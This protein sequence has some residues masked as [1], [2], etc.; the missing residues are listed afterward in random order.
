M[1]VRAALVGFFALGLGLLLPRPALAQAPN[2]QISYA[3][4]MKAKP[5]SWAEY[6]MSREGEEQ[7]VRARYTLVRKDPKGVALEIDSK[8]KESHIFID[9]V[10]R[11]GV[12]LTVEV[13]DGEHRV[14]AI[15]ALSYRSMVHKADWARRHGFFVSPPPRVDGNVILSGHGSLGR[16]YLKVDGADGNRLGSKV[17]LAPGKRTIEVRAAR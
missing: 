2:N 12:P 16:A 13:P 4:I 17:A 3:A 8:T 6:L 5:G 9:G 1:I 11:G 15:T 14:E 10:D 7:Q